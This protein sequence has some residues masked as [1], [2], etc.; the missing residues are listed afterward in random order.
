VAR[1]GDVGEQRI[2]AGILTVMGIEAAEGPAHRGPRADHGAI[3]VNGQPWQRQA[4]EGLDDEVM[5]ELDQRGQRALGKLAQPV[6]H[7]ARRRQPRQ[8][9][10]ARDQRIAGD[11]PQMLQPA[12]AHIQ[13]RQYEQGEPA[14][15]IIPARRGTRGPH[16]LWQIELAQISLS[17]DVLIH[18]F[19]NK[20]GAGLLAL[21]NEGA[22][23]KGL[24]LILYD[25]G[26]TD[27]FVLATVDQ[28]GKLKT[29]LSQIIPLPT[30]P[31]PAILEKV[32]YRM[33]MDVTVSGDDLTVR[34]RAFRHMDPHDPDS[35]IE[36]QPIGTLST[37]TP[38][39]LAALGLQGSGEVGIVASAINAVVDSSVANFCSSEPPV[40]GIP[41]CEVIRRRK[42]DLIPTEAEASMGF[43]NV[44]L[45]AVFQVKNVGTVSAPASFAR[46]D[47]P[48]IAAPPVT[49]PIPALAPSASSA[50]IV[51]SPPAGCFNP[52][53]E[54]T[55]TVDS[56]FDVG[57]SDEGNNGA[58]G[59]CPG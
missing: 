59:I 55:I 2:V 38:L 30:L 37:P 33:I 10:E 19:N 9:A 17:A 47:F 13:Q 7:R 6:A 3:D 24:V 26:N 45:Q 32:W 41:D 57:E 4:R 50:T 48:G 12:R 43:C 15:P 52:D 34:G 58:N 21:F 20:K 16:P 31:P 39:S 36:I 28:A 35:A 11:V 23:Q 42:A 1:L 29:L 18:R 25:A 54:F 51:I 53:C 14:S 8:P 27:G 5:V 44:A 46:V 49:V 56:G 40:P 22:G